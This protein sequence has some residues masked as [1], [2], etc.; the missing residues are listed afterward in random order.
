MVEQQ[1]DFTKFF[2]MLDTHFD[3]QIK[4]VDYDK[5]I[6]CTITNA[7]NAEQGEY[8]VT[9]GSSHFLAYSADK[10]YKKNDNIYVLIPE[11][12]FNATKQIIGKH[13]SAD[14]KSITYISPFENYFD[15]TG[16]LF[17]STGRVGLL[18]NDTE[19]S[20]EET[21]NIRIG[22]EESSFPVERIIKGTLYHYLGT[23]DGDK[24]SGFER[25]GIKADFESFTP[26]AI[27]GDYGLELGIS[28]TD[29]DGAEGFT[30]VR[31]NSTDMWGNPYNFGSPFTQEQVFDISKYNTIKTIV[32]YFYET[33]NFYTSFE[34]KLPCYINEETKEKLPDNLF[35]DNVYISLGYETN[36][37]EKLT[38][39]TRDTT[40][41]SGK[42]TNDQNK[43]TLHLRWSHILPDVNKTCV[44]ISRYGKT[45]ED[46]SSVL[47]Y[48]TN[49]DGDGRAVKVHYYVYD[50]NS[51]DALAGQYWKEI[52]NEDNSF[53]YS[54]VPDVN[55]PNYYFKAI[56]ELTDEKG[57]EQ[58]NEVNKVALD[59]AE[60]L[61][62][63]YTQELNGYLEKEK[64]LKQKRDLAASID[65]GNF[66][67]YD[68]QL[69]QIEN[70]IKEKNKQIESVKK[71]AN[72]INSDY[73]KY[74]TKIST[75]LLEFTCE[76]DTPDPGAVD[77][78]NGLGIHIIDNQKGIYRIYDTLTNNLV[79][80][81]DEY[82]YRTARM[83]FTSIMANNAY[84]GD[85]SQVRWYIPKKN[86]M[87]VAPEFGRTYNTED[88]NETFQETEDWYIITR[89][90]AKAIN[91]TAGDSYSTVH[92]T[93]DQ[94]F[95]IK[96][97][98]LQ[99]STN[100]IIKCEIT[101]NGIV[102]P[103]Q[104][105][106]IFGNSGSNG[107]DNTVILKL[108]EEWMANGKYKFLQNIKDLSDEAK[109]ALVNDYKVLDTTAGKPSFDVRTTY[110]YKDEEGI[111]RPYIYSTEEDWEKFLKDN[112]VYKNDVQYISKSIENK[113]TIPADH[114]DDAREWEIKTF[115]V[116]NNHNIQIVYVKA[117]VDCC[118]K[119]YENYVAPEVYLRYTDLNNQVQSIIVQRHN[120]VAGQ[121]WGV[122]PTAEDRNQKI[123]AKAGTPVT[124][125]SAG[126]SRNG[127]RLSFIYDGATIIYTYT[128]SQEN[129]EFEYKIYKY[130]GKDFIDTGRTYMNSFSWTETDKALKMVEQSPPAWTGAGDKN[131]TTHYIKL[132]AELYN[133]KDELQD[134]SK[135]NIKWS[136]F[137]QG[138]KPINPG[139]F[140]LSKS[141]EGEGSD[142]EWHLYKGLN[143]LNAGCILKC[144]IEFKIEGSYPTTYTG[145]L[146][147]AWR[148]DYNL[149]FSGAD[150]I[151]YNTAGS[152]PTYYRE[153]FLLNNIKPTIT[154]HYMVADNTK[155]IDTT[156][157]STMYWL[158]KITNAGIISPPSMFFNDECYNYW[159][160][161]EISGSRLWAQPILILQNAWASS[162]LNQ[163]DGS[164]TLDKEKGTILSTMVGA[165][166]KDGKNQFNG[167]L[168]GDV[169]KGAGDTG[170]GRGIYGYKDGVQ[171]FGL[172]T[173]GT[174]FLGK[175]GRAQ[176]EFDG[177]H[178]TI[179]NSAYV[180][181]NG[182][183]I[184]FDGRDGDGSFI[185]MKRKGDSFE[186]IKLVDK[187]NPNTA[188]GE[189][190]YQTFSFAT[191]IKYYANKEC[192]EEVGITL[193]DKN[194][195]SYNRDTVFAYGKVQNDST[196]YDPNKT[197]YTDKDCS[198]LASTP[199]TADLYN[200]D[201]SKYYYKYKG[202]DPIGTY[203]S[204][205]TYYSNA[206]C[207]E[208]AQGPVK[209]ENFV[210]GAWWYKGVGLAENFNPDA[211]YYVDKELKTPATGAL[212]SEN[213]KENNIVYYVSGD[214]VLP[215]TDWITVKDKTLYSD[216]QCTQE[217]TARINAENKQDNVI[218]YWQELSPIE[219]ATTD[220]EEG[221]T[222]YD[223]NGNVAQGRITYDTYEP[224]KYYQ[225]ETRYHYE[226][227][228]I[229]KDT[230]YDPNATYY[231]KILNTYIEIKFSTSKQFQETLQEQSIYIKNKVEYILYP[232]VTIEKIE[233]NRK[234]INDITFY[235][236]N[237]GTQIAQSNITVDNYKETKQYYEYILREDIGVNIEFKDNITY[238][239]DKELLNLAVGK[240][241]QA[242]FNPDS[243]TYY[244]WNTSNAA[245]ADITFDSNMNYYSAEPNPLDLKANLITS[246]TIN[247]L[248]FIP[249]QW[250]T[251]EVPQIALT[252]VE[253]TVYYAD[254]TCDDNKKAQGKICLT[255]YIANT[256]Y[257]TYA[258]Q[259]D[260]EDFSSNIEYFSEVELRNKA[261][262][263]WSSEPLTLYYIIS[264]TIQTANHNWSEDFDS[265]LKYYTNENR[266]TEALIPITKG[267][268][269]QNLPYYV[270]CCIQAE[271]D[272]NSTKK[273]YWDMFGQ[274]LA[275]ITT[276][277]EY[278]ANKANLWMQ[279]SYNTRVKI[280][281]KSP[282]F[283][284]QNRNGIKVMSVDDNGAKIGGWTLSD[285]KLYDGNT[286]LY[287]KNQID[288][289]S[290]AGSESKNNW[291]I[292]IGSRFGVDN[293]GHLYASEGVFSGHISSKSGDIGG[294]AINSNSLKAGNITLNSDGGINSNDRFIVD[295]NGNL[296]A[297]NAYISGTIE[298]SSGHIGGWSI[299]NGA[300]M[301]G[302]TTLSS[303]GT[304]SGASISGAYIKG[305][306][307]EAD[308]L[309][310]G[311][312]HLTWN[313]I[314]VVSSLS[315]IVSHASLPSKRF[316]T[317]VNYNSFG[318]VT[319]VNWGY[320]P[321]ARFVNAVQITGHRVKFRVLGRPDGAASNVITGD[322]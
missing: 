255:N 78:V 223:E 291:R 21:F 181:D 218:Y 3:E 162:V 99:S 298:S 91:A 225:K 158:P 98:L 141:G 300:I 75:D 237:T 86:T 37:E 70:L 189:R 194:Y 305:S 76:T 163:W 48:I 286:F 133:S 281:T 7:D 240:I 152:T 104:V 89:T 254:E 74:I 230:E 294:W 284:I 97:H 161:L 299:S 176:L 289:K 224:G 239:L 145:Y 82:T 168:M 309:V 112:I 192:S 157:N 34:D 256:Y 69:S 121:T 65:A 61:I 164:L 197:Y 80:G 32:V 204:A 117:D 295:P 249:Y 153:P 49:Y 81:V 9:D 144:E 314:T 277:E 39:Y 245:G 320:S 174:A 71:A 301:G 180:N 22:E 14:D 93:T 296:H 316:V 122:W 234:K 220:F 108:D 185:D 229:S 100:N 59:K 315:G 275:N 268:Y 46:D 170:A 102:Y 200:K 52:L 228:E 198:T 202:I 269:G 123:I 40:T 312:N 304:I 134:L 262:A 226:Y 45:A 64:D 115:T 159:L 154:P 44:A 137:E 187:R 211:V 243:S 139:G 232:S 16:N 101:R 109:D 199:L 235:T 171:A 124:L 285:D 172:L 62:T 290:I 87:I 321:A 24:F 113:W 260:T 188:E 222:Y 25:L 288:Y 250:Y 151:I 88:A 179:Q 276:K 150:R 209:E 173:D 126:D 247:S 184:D 215:K 11:G 273:Y 79:N 58:L 311:G 183:R 261:I 19:A 253:G 306:T 125:V 246:G 182:M 206:D 167:V 201:R 149:N 95:R 53:E 107:T 20:T 272:F 263:N 257:V 297:E 148:S 2:D 27:T 318:G 51:F 307:I 106:L 313:V 116:P 258:K 264:K 178:G 84:S 212:N 193:N 205:L 73:S 26:Q 142:V 227:Q 248:N 278:N 8:T 203:N 274:N 156:Y 282:F 55:K 266:T 271:G 129:P 92:G 238:Y 131:G 244:T 292:A 231:Q 132:S 169:Q 310:V 111:F 6:L 42:N 47:K 90:G 287:S 5:T 196:E 195:T 143:G 94:Q 214:R 4:K 35:V 175:K 54:F 77:Y 236:D 119:K 280:S 166:S 267:T 105:E 136:F 186:V 12:D 18:A 15:I 103:A 57:I 28:Y 160:D 140:R 322:Q 308:H 29:K 208:I 127:R 210:S 68:E 259:C 252:F 50:K 67:V 303:D 120:D 114:K 217:A 36:N 85:I 221:K 30:T 155:T 177:D 63:Q 135:S 38:L 56:I 190:D 128:E 265:R 96:R 279:K 72:K 283:Q 41:Y 110:Y 23:Y 17:N 1:Y 251:E 213:I 207:T 216:A 60:K 10:K 130:N 242:T 66:A 241:T 293:G 165:G 302:N 233:K 146:P 33:P 191:G 270:Q 147:V 43:K 138:G 319:S 219:S 317:N 31:L 13:T 83:V 118:D